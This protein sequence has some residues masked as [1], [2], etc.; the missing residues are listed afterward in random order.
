MIDLLEEKPNFEYYDVSNARTKNLQ[1]Q[2]VGSSAI[3]KDIESEN[4]VVKT[5]LLRII[6]E[7][8]THNFYQINRVQGYDWSK[9]YYDISILETN[10]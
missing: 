3:T 6:K 8:T 5:P 10:R 1:K 4:M 2:W 7:T 9:D